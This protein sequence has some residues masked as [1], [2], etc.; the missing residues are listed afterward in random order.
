MTGR[1]RPLSRI[2]GLLALTEE[3]LG[4]VSRRQLR[5]L[6]VTRDHERSQIE[7]Q[8]WSRATPRVVALL[9]GA[10]DRDQWM[11]VAQLHGGQAAQLFAETALEAHGMT[12]WELEDALILVPHGLKVPAANGLVVHHSRRAGSA[13]PVLRRG[14]RCEPA[15]R[16]V[17]SSADRMANE[18]RALGLVLAAVQQ[19]FVAPKQCEGQLP[20]GRGGPTCR[21]D[22]PRP[23]TRRCRRRL[24]A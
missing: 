12:G 2:P 3:Q 11:W 8:R 4:V 7:A 6:G 21:R 5:A 10:L 18:R 19:R 20:I 13:R 1:T 24:A 14:L 23:G 16:A 15:A 22:P 17:V 9:T